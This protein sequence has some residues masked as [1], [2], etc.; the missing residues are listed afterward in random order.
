M[1]ITAL[2]VAVAATA[3]SACATEVAYGPGPGYP[4]AA[5]GWDGY[6][7]DYY[8]PFYDGYWGEDGGFYYRSGPHAGWNKDTGGHFTKEAR[9]GAHPVHGHGGGGGG[10]HDEHR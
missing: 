1:K 9:S 2:L 3:L 5:V 10:G 6:Y 8:G 4:V 7:D